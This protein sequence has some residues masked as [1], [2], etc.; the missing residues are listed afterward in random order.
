M[1]KAYS[2]N[3]L[4]VMQEQEGEDGQ[5]IE[6]PTTIPYELLQRLKANIKIDITPSSPYD[7]Y[8]EEQTLGNLLAGG[9]ITFEEY[10]E[11]L[12]EGSATRKDK[13]QEILE[14][15]KEKETELMQM[16]MEANQLD[17]AMN[18]VMQIHADNSNRIENI[19]REGEE[20][21]GQLNGM[22]QMQAG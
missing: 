22:S 2:V 21:G 4:Q 9:F 6:V 15:R 7:I 5:T 17:S 3:G 11:L 16:Q 8:A 18:Q 20:I 13:L 14:M 1:W 19:A 12:P 10:V